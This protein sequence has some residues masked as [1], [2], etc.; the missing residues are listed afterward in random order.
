MTT[1]PTDI[2]VFVHLPKSAGRSVKDV[3]IPWMTK[4]RHDHE[5]VNSDLRKMGI[6]ELGLDL[7]KTATENRADRMSTGLSSIIEHGQAG[8]AKKTET[9]WHDRLNSSAPGPLFYGAFGMGTC[10]YLGPARAGR[11]C[12]YFAILRDPVDRLISEHNWCHEV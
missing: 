5:A 8:A 4:Q 2:A 10:D 12:A 6:T 3:V 9:M 7:W 11:P 1:K